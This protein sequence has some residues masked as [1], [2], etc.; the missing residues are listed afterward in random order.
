MEE[1]NGTNK[2][3]MNGGRKSQVNQLVERMIQS[4]NPWKHIERA[5][6]IIKL[7]PTFITSFNPSFQ[8]KLI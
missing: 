4:I 1:W 5:S 7:A 3:W 2:E 8:P 6:G